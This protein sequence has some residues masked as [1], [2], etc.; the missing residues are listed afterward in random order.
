MKEVEEGCAGFRCGLNLVNGVD[1][2]GEDGGVDVE[3]NKETF[4][5]VP[6]S[7]DV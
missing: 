5:D 7:V 6:S 1:E 3:L 2:A 4:D